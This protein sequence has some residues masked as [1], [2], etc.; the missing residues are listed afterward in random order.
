[1]TD[2]QKNS[3]FKALAS[4]STYEVGLEFGFDKRYTTKR[5]I[6]NAVYRI[7]QEVLQNLDKFGIPQ[8]TAELVQNVMAERSKTPSKTPVDM[9]EQALIEEGDT[10]AIVIG[11]RNKAGIVLHKKLDYL[12][13]HPKML[14]N[15]NLATLAKTFGI[16][17]DKAQIIQGMATENIAIK[18]KIDDNMSVDDVK[19]ALLK[20][21]EKTMEEKGRT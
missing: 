16:L 4:K 2:S 17:F 1:V 5:S 20:F 3:L 8:D 11:G 19:N 15:E 13:R 10:E 9:G 12:N 14:M 6:Q 7:Y 18:A 21:R